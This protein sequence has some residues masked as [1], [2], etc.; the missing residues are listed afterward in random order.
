M[1]YGMSNPKEAMALAE[2]LE[3]ERSSKMISGIAQ[4]YAGHAGAE[5]Y[6]FF[7]QALTGT[8][9]QGFDKLGLMNS[10][11]LYLSRQ[12]PEVISKSLDVYADMSVNGSFYMKMF[13][14]QNLTYLSEH[15]GAKIKELKTELEGHEKNN[16]AAYADKARKDIATYESLKKKFDAMIADL[17]KQSGDVQ[18]I[19]EE[20]GAEE[21]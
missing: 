14:P 2:K 12:E 20:E 10:F 1:N 3:S 15:C 9:V 4:L 6:D 16:D 21:E 13:L 8:I 18:I 19:I 11:T 7:E 17:E 5:K